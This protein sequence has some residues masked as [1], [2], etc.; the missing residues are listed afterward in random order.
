MVGRVFCRPLSAC[1]R[2]RIIVLLL[3]AFFICSPALAAVSI[4]VTASGLS[5]T[6]PQVGLGGTVAFSAAVTGSTQTA[7]NW[8]VVGGGTISSTGVYTAPAAMP[9]SNQV[10]VVATLASDP[11]TSGSYSLALAFPVPVITSASPTQAIAGVTIPIALTGSNFQP[12]IS[13]L[14]NGVPA[15]TT[16]ASATSIT[17]QVTAAPGTTTSL[18]LLPQN[19]SPMMGTPAAFSLSSTAEMNF[20]ETNNN[21]AANNGQVVIGTTMTVSTVLNHWSN[22]PR[23][24]QLQG[25][26]S[27]SIKGSVSGY[28]VYTPPPSLPANTSVTITA[29]MSTNSNLTTSYSFSLV[30]PPPTVTAVSPTQ[31]L[32]GGTQPVTLT[33][34][35]FVA[36]AVVTVNGAALA[37]TFN[38]A[39][40][41][42]AQVPVGNTASAP[43]SLAVQNP[44]PG[45]GLSAAIS[46]PVAANTVS[47]APSGQGGGTVALGGSLSLAAT[48]AGSEQTA[49]NW[50]V[51][52]GGGSISTAGIYTA[53]A[54]MSGGS[55]VVTAALASNPAITGSYPLTLANPVPVIAS[56]SPTQLMT[57]GAQAVT[58]SGSGFV[59][60]TVV[61]LGGA[62][63]TTS[64]GGGNSLT[65]QVPV[66]NTATGSLN[67]I[68]QN[69]A[70]GGG[71]GAAFSIPISTNTVTV[72]PSG[73]GGTVV[74]GSSLSLGATVT[75][76][77]QTAV[78]WSVNGVGTISAS[79]VYTAPAN[80]PTGNEVV[81]ATLA[82]NPA[83]TGSYQLTLANPVPVV[84]S[85]SPAQLLTGGTQPVTLS[86]TGF[87]AGTAVTLNGTP[88]TTVYNSANLLTVQIPVGNTAT[89]S[90]SLVAQNPAPGGGSSAAV[91]IPIST[92]TVTV[93]P[94][95]Q[96]GTVVLGS[97]L[98]LAATVTGSAQ[99]AVNWSVSG[100]GSITTAGVYSA[101]TTMPGGAVVVT[102]TL[103]SNTAITGTYQVAL[104]N[105]PPVVSSVS[106]TQLVIGSTQTVTLSGSGFLPTTTVTLGGTALS[107]AYISYTQLTVQ[108]PVAVNASG[109]LSFQVQ[110]PG[111]ASA[112]AFSETIAPVSVTVTSAALS[113]SNPSVALGSSTSFSAAVTGSAQTAV[114]W[115][116][117]G[118]GTISST[119]TYT[120]PASVPSNNQVTIVATLASNS[121][122]TGSYSLAL[123][124][125][126]PVITS[127]SP[128]QADAGA[129]IPITLTGTNF[130]PGITVLVNGVAAPT[131]YTSSTS[132]T[133]Q[134]AA[135]PNTN[136]ALPLLPQNPSPMTGTPSAFS[137]NPTAALELTETNN[138]G[139]TNN[140]QVVLGTTLTLSTVLYH[141]SNDVRNWQL[142]GAGT[143]TLQGGSLDGGAL[144]T[145]PTSIPAN[146][147]VT[148]TV[149]MSSNPNLS[150][151]YNFS[152]TD[153]VPAITATKPAQLLTGGTQS[154]TV[155]G[156][157]FVAG[158]VVTLNG[159]ALTTTY[160]S[161]TSLTAQVPVGNAATG[162]LNLIAQNPAPGGGSSS[163]FAVPITV[164]SI[165][166][167]PPT[168]SGGVVTLNKT[169]NMSAA[170]TGSEQTAVTW[171]VSGGGS[172][173]ST[174]TYT[175]PATLP[176]GTV[177][178]TATL[179]SNSAITGTYQLTVNNPVPA[180][181]GTNPSQAVAGATVPITI[182]GGQFVPNTVILVNGTAVPTT[183]QSL[184]SV[185][186]QVT[187]SAGSS[188]N[189]TIQAQSPTPGGGTSTTSVTLGT[190]TLQIT[191][192]DP[193]GTNTGTARL[194]VPVG[195]STVNTD[196]AHGATSWTLQGAGTL[197]SGGTNNA[198]ATYAPP[199]TMPAN[200]TVT[201]T[202]YLSALPALTTSYTFTLVNPQPTLTAATPSQ[203][204]TGATQ[205]VALSGSGFVSGTTVTLNGKSLATTYQDYDDATVQIPVTA[206]A[207]GTLNLQIVNPAPGGGSAAFT[208]S[209]QPNSIALTASDADGSNTGTAELGVN[210]TMSAAVTGSSQTAVKWSLTG[211]GS[212]S[213]SGVYTAPAAMPSSQAVTIQASLVSN[214]A[215]TASYS[216][217]IINPVPVIGAASPATV[218]AGATTMV[219]LTGTGFVPSTVIE[220]GGSTVP[221]TYVSSTSI[222]AQITAGASATGE[223]Q[224]Q[225]YTSAFTGGLSDF[226]AVAISS[227]ISATTA[228]RL[229]DQTTFGPTTSLIQHVQSE[230][231][232]AWLAEQYNTPQTVL[233]VVPQNVPSYCGDAEHCV[234]SE[235]WQTVLTGND[236][237]R[238][239]VAF[240][241]SELFV[242]S[243]DDVSG[244]GIQYYHNLLA[245]DA[246]TNWYTIMNDVSLS[247]AMGI[248]LNMV[249]SRAAAPGQ[250]ANE[251][252]ARENMQLFNM[253]LDLINQNGTSQL[254]SY[255]NQ[256]PAYTEAQVEQFSR[257]FT[258]WTFANTDGST[259]SALNNPVNFYHQLVAVESTHDETA[260]TLLSGVTLP[261][262]QTA[263]QDLAQALTNVFDHPNVP[264]FVAQQLIQHLVKSQPSPA[265]ISRVAAVFVNNGN[266]V[267]GDMQAVL[268]AIFTDPEARAGDTAPQASDGHLREP[269]LWLTAAMRGLGFVNVDP[270]NYYQYLSIDTAVLDEVPYQ[271]PAVFNFFPPSYVIPGTTLNAPEFGLENTASATDRLTLAD[272]MVNNNIWRFNVDLSATSPLGQ[273]LVSQGPAALVNSLNSLFLYGTMDQNTASAITSEIST[274]T[275]PAQA[276]RLA[277]YLVIT[278][279][280]YKILH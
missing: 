39:T 131:T 40:S 213:S 1:L 280:Q 160:N 71:L 31:L 219:T 28:V 234:E 76:S 43:L 2:N 111:A 201:I 260:K 10:A 27:I 170:V 3:G 252:F 12:G 105:P 109:G 48:V 112:A 254:D 155:T 55:V 251:N 200:S 68:A 89:G 62:A 26:G 25:A 42:T 66:G 215:I 193:D 274:I 247:P 90:L 47:V 24:W 249:N 108:V 142:Q 95:G 150:T 221:T 21:G 14:V 198:T 204:L 178:V 146:P 128:A 45:G 78:N 145:P 167:T 85:A 239:R 199:Q 165:N 183:Y 228:A 211:P 56:A 106:P 129:T 11:S 225:A 49:V 19:P 104:A 182:T 161:A 101:P 20:T 125:P 277:V 190:A 257:V 30:N 79:G 255:G 23:V 96:G 168:S 114:N 174:G 124:S 52:S 265:Y 34:T 130:A 261:A 173:S 153:P 189:L 22:D 115:S 13:V 16:Y 123:L 134:I 164:N 157:G 18:S 240:A 195:L 233:P 230:G 278:S 244:W 154:V 107:T 92:N 226:F 80:M 194:G 224:V 235:W 156:T 41:V 279:S 74:L 97:S 7:V 5:G 180:V 222:Q 217:S 99:T 147:N 151:T 60:G 44:A 207:S 181:Y 206:T 4:T 238:Q 98:S 51:S 82:S 191:S 84:A 205:T 75:G 103:A 237:L 263:E 179:T 276:L 113:A 169:L 152:L 37:T 133:A 148:V 61:T 138:N 116:V 9:S 137:L 203:L 69:P 258:G 33:G 166:V 242:V 36:G 88:L 187:A 135:A 186:A 143:L 223:L 38:S 250:I 117:T 264:P 29:T 77:T 162:S 132:I 100:G 93:A 273:V 188:S 50:S 144:Y 236:Q 184:T 35:G 67:L 86:G 32:T 163:A 73:Q 91:S 72:A 248:Y 202:S 220:V 83:I 256:I 6:N 176:T 127:A 94:S 214:P 149:T 253:G 119:G 46:I 172:I 102:A 197:T 185:V 227:P 192:V 158:T 246:F 243:S 70:P 53:P 229:L 58:L 218:P 65:V 196:T 241:L 177:I 208:E 122:I 64:Y 171:S 269:I 267:R 212:L 17:A 266:N 59:P 57:G 159:T 8:S 175:A 271:S 232:T 275:N 141:W 245:T 262:G 118:S 81:I 126:V 15:P 268:T 209:I 272:T 63:L 121:S 231:V 270:N 139:T 216:F 210:V 136:T 259:P 110:N 120:A 140:G 54:T 87:V